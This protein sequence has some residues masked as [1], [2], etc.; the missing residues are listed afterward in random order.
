MTE[1]VTPNRIPVKGGGFNAKG[2]LTIPSRRADHSGHPIL[3]TIDGRLGCDCERYTL[4][5]AHDV[6]GPHCAHVQRAAEMLEGALTLST[7]R[8]AKVLYT[9]TYGDP[10]RKEIR[11]ARRAAQ[12]DQPTLEELFAK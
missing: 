7:H 8:N 1:K 5:R 6:Y 10:R 2:Q 12:P 11:L 4:G 9:A 3:A